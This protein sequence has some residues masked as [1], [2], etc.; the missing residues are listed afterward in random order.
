ME[1]KLKTKKKKP[2]PKPKTL[3]IG[4][5]ISLWQSLTQHLA[6]VLWASAAFKAFAGSVRQLWQAKRLRSGPNYLSD[7]L[8]EADGVLFNFILSVARSST[9]TLD[10]NI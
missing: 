8:A 7:A 9:K 3:A 5:A 6:I 1:S 2:K 4:E 10:L